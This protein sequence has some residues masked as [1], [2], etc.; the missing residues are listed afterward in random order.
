MCV[1][2]RRLGDNGRVGHL[3][4]SLLL[5]I[6]ALILWSSEDILELRKSEISLFRFCLADRLGCVIILLERFRPSISVRL[7]HLSVHW[8]IGLRIPRLPDLSLRLKPVP[9]EHVVDVSC[10]L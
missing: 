7:R 2:H 6:V 8:Q 5:T 9:L 4:R 1:D 10:R 3:R